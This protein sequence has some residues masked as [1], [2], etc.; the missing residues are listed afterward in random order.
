[1]AI[2]IETR[3]RETRLDSEQDRIRDLSRCGL[4]DP[5]SLLSLISISYCLD[6][7]VH[8]IK[9]HS[10]LT[11]LVSL[12]TRRWL[13]WHNSGSIGSDVTD[14]LSPSLTENSNILSQ[15]QRPPSLYA[16]KMI[17]FLMMA[18]ISVSERSILSGAFVRTL[19]VFSPDKIPHGWRTGK[20]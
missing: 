17:I 13:R 19:C 7:I 12:L 1:M 15:K 3:P 18:S 5:P 2:E 8:L 10:Q 4:S 6:T 20:T 9:T 16:R 14:L 11:V